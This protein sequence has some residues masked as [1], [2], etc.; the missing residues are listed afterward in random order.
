VSSPALPGAPGERLPLLGA[1]LHP[2]STV[3]RGS[4]VGSN[5]AI[6]QGAVVDSSVLQDGLVVE[7]GA[8]VRNSVVAVGAR[9]GPRTMVESAVIGDG[10]SVGADYEI[11]PGTPIWVDAVL[12]DMSIR[13]SSDQD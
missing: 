6:Y 9:I 11:P 10:A 7:A 12:D 13:V 2:T 4:A 3:R 8:I 5:A 1:H